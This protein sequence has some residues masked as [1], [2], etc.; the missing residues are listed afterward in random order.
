MYQQKGYFGMG[1]QTH[2]L[3]RSETCHAVTGQKKHSCNYS[4]HLSP[5]ATYEALSEHSTQHVLWK[6][7]W[8]SSFPFGFSL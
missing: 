1:L 6:W 5:T 8:S 7:Q 3:A 2:I 4:L